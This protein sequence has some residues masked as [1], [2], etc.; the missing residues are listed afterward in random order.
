[1]GIPL[2]EG[3]LAYWMRVLHVIVSTCATCEGVFYIRESVQ[4]IVHPE[5]CHMAVVHSRTLSGTSATPNL[6]LPN[7]T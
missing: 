2:L 6:T 1:M 3:P 5:I 4:D 7:L